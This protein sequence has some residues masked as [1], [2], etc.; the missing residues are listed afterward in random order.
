MMREFY[1]KFEKW[2]RSAKTLGAPQGP[3]TQELM[4]LMSTITT[5][6]PPEK[7]G[8]RVYDDRK[9]F[10]SLKTAVA[11]GKTL[12]APQWEA[13][14]RLAVK[15]RDQL[16]D[17][18]ACA[19]KYGF[20]QELETTRE[21]RAARDAMI[22][23]WQK[24]REVAAAAAPPQDGLADVFD[25]MKAIA[26]KAPEK[27]FRRAFDEKKFF[28]SLREQNAKGRTLSEKQLTALGRLAVRYK[29][30]L[31]GFDRIASVLHLEKQPD[32]AAAPAK[33]LPMG[34]ADEL[35]RK[36]KTII[37]WA[38]PRKIRGR[39]YDDKAFFESLAKQRAAG[40]V[41]SEKQLAALKKTAAKYSIE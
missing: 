10:K 40:K 4:N 26:W 24:K 8:T 3:K 16:P 6:N 39:V 7:S 11:G 9:F 29:D 28:E 36:M 25:A 15:Y 18:D 41:L 30:Q 35:I 17:L 38:E 19:E 33:P 5:W 23:E 1:E 20:A 37:S 27:S 14:L 13:L 32:A 22:R 34:E 2:L 31:P 21:E 12:S